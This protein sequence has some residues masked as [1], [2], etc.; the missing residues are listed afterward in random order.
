MS[1]E[2]VDSLSKYLAQAGYC[3][4]R[5]AVEII[6]EG[7]VKVNGVKIMEPG[8]K[9]QPKDVIKIGNRVIR[10]EEKIYILLNKPR[11][12]I[13]TVSDEH[14]RKTIMDLL[15]DAPKV[16]F[17]PVGRLDGETTGL[18]VLTN[19]GDLAQRLS[20]PSYEVQKTYIATLDRALAEEDRLAIEKGVKLKDGIVKVDEI[21]IT[22]PKTPYMVRITLH[23][24][25]NRVI[26]RL[27]AHYK[28][29]VNELDR[30]TYAGLTKNELPRGRWRFLKPQD[31][32]R[33][34][35]NKKGVS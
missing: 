22:H 15:V 30:V 9:V 2:K 3:S 29:Y 12:Y 8:H 18:I 10:H 34:T 35:K 13:S 23:S 5:Q 32:I 33:L 16:R 11:G 21:Q 17:Y 24:G 6:K 27:F 19:D 1:D 25:K 4:R 31:I 14:D 26:R 7:R 28:Y 20:H